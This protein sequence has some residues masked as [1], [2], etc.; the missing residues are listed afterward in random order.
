MATHEPSPVAYLAAILATEKGAPTPY[1]AA[2]DAAELI[3]LGNRAARIAVNVCNGI[4]R[5]DPA[6]GQVLA[7]WTESDDAKAEK[8]R[9]R[10]KARAAEILADYGATVESVA[11]DPRGYCLKLRL[12]S[13]RSNS[14]GSGIWGV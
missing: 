14:M 7:S 5:Y 12:A 8:A 4:P 2:R 3:R 13:G 6:A 11:G 9:G 10:I 1:R